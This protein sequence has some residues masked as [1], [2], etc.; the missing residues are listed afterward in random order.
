MT[1]RAAASRL[2]RALF[3]TVRRDDPARTGADLQAYADI[4]SQHADLRKTLASPGVPV[5]VKHKI[6]AGLLE[7]RPTTEHI[8]RF[9]QILAERDR[10]ALLPEIAAAFQLRLLDF[11]QVV[12]A[13]VTTAVPLSAD[14]AQALE[15]SLA[16]TPGKRVI[17]TTQVDPRIIGGVVAR[18]GSRVYDGSVAHHL[19][20][21]KAQLVDAAS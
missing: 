20:R 9:L 4:L 19:A 10:L 17:V 16:Q 3:D 7:L 2:A 21:V 18:I 12:R 11:Q 13:D 15:Q 1:S 5:P 6:M 8:A 14:R